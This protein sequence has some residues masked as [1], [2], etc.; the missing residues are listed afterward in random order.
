MKTKLNKFLDN[1]INLKV[2]RD[3]ALII[4]LT[5]SK[6]ARSPTLWN[7]AY[8][9]LNKK[10]RMFPADVKEENLGKLFMYLKSNKHFLGSSVTVPYKE[11]IIKYL[12]CIEKNAN[13][14]GSV[15]TIVNKN[16]KLFGFN[17]DY[18]GSMY[19]LK[20]MKMSRSKQEILIFGCGGAGK[21]II[22]S[23]INYFN[24][25]KIKILNR[26]RNKLKKFLE[27]LKIENKNSIRMIPSIAY[28]KKLKSLD[29][30]L[31]CTSIGFD[32]WVY[33]NGYYNLMNF[34]PIT[35][36]NYKKI[37]KA[38]HESFKKK[39]NLEIR[40]NTKGTINF[41]ASFQNLNIFDIIYQPL[42][43]NLIKAGLILGH[44]TKNGLD[45]NLMQAVEGFKIVNNFKN[46][47]KIMKG[48]KN[49]K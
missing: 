40:K 2:N 7:N 36:I 23:V 29:L 49:G 22:V 20:K 12:D 42:E 37:S 17:T 48:M 25:S 34:C 13:S 44:K 43:T 9:S 11:K 16:G 15:N 28:L 1:K 41:L 27:K 31:N 5:P 39:N 10:T 30:I 19:S 38:N 32:G 18:Y 3:F 4:G 8:K 33:N 24:N 6:G 26:N 45:M 35:K 21:A 47:D 14:I 46:K